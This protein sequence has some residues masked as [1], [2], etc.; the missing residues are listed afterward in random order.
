MSVDLDIQSFQCLQ[1]LRNSCTPGWPEHPPSPLVNPPSA[2]APLP[3]S[4]PPLFLSPFFSP[5]IFPHPIFPP[6]FLF[7]GRAKL[8]INLP[9]SMRRALL[10]PRFQPI[11]ARICWK[12]DFFGF[13]KVQWLHLTSKA[14]KSVRCSRR[15]FA[16]FSIPIITEL[17]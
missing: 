7:Q 12:N 9:T 13:P 1:A 17:G 2:F 14:D 3:F 11:T 6:I 10:R 16:G 5:F 4:S 8:L 15:I